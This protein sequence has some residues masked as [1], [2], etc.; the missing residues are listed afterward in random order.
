MHWRCLICLF[1]PYLINY[2][3]SKAT[4]LCWPAH[5]KWWNMFRNF[6]DLAMPL[7]RLVLQSLPSNPVSV[8]L[9]MTSLR[10]PS[11]FQQ[12]MDLQI[13]S[14]SRS[15]CR[16]LLVFHGLWMSI[17]YNS[18]T[19]RVWPAKPRWQQL[20]RSQPRLLAV[21]ANA[22]QTLIFFQLNVPGF[23]MVSKSYSM[24]VKTCYSKTYM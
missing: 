6:H 22:T 13:T 23:I 12:I 17:V 20:G 14:K 2:I 1:D 21:P 18:N 7:Q 15:C 11:L 3:T 24:I 8:W 16:Y 9:S 10:Y 5:Q 19:C 4:K